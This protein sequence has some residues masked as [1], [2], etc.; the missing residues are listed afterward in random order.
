MKDLLSKHKA[1]FIMPASPVDGDRRAVKLNVNYKH[2]GFG[3][4]RGSYYQ[5][6]TMPNTYVDHYPR[7]LFLVSIVI[8]LLSS[9]DAFF[10]LL[11]I[12][13][14]AVEL[15][16][17]MDILLKSSPSSFVLYKVMLTA[18]STI[19]LVVHHNFVILRLFKAEKVLYAMSIGYLLLA[20]WEIHLLTIF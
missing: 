13:N 15:N 12:N 1:Q 11:L 14:G 4:Q 20:C 2:L 7:K 18:L 16:G 3:G 8:M 5:N 6:R 9:T 19:F 17:L 10:T